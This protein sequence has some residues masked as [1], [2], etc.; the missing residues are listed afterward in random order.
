[1]SGAGDTVIAVI[2][3]CLASGMAVRDAVEMA[4]I[5]GGLVCE[6]V[7]VVPVTKEMLFKEFK[8]SIS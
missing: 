2:T 1:V 3:L 8:G 5:A 4:N 6:Y 7:G